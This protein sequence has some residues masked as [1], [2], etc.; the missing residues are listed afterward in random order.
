[1]LA[2]DANSDFEGDIDTERKTWTVGY[3]WIINEQ[4]DVY[5]NY[6]ND[7]VDDLGDGDTYGV[8]ARF[9]F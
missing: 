8:G 1:M 4:F 5:A 2:A 7:D 3:D 9:K 6:M